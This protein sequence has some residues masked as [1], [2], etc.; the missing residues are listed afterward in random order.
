MVLWDTTCA[1]TKKSEIGKL[2]SFWSPFKGTIPKLIP[3]ATDRCASK[4]DAL[5][6]EVARGTLFQALVSLGKEHE[7]TDLL[8]AFPAEVRIGDIN[9][10]KKELK[11][12]PLTETSK[13]SIMKPSGASSG[14]IEVHVGRYTFWL[15]APPK[16]NL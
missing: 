10:K 7:H 16:V 12:P 3:K 14:A 15:L 1:V 9:Y 13:I 5:N 11:L 4:V 8:Y 2:Q 6:I